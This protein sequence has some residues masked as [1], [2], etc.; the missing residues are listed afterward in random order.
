[1]GVG[2]EGLLQLL[3]LP[4]SERSDREKKRGLHV[5]FCVFFSFACFVDVFCTG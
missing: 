2:G 4:C 5:V 3:L 1:M